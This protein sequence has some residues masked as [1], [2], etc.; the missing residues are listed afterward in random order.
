VKNQKG[1][2]CFPL[3]LDWLW[4]SNTNGRIGGIISSLARGSKKKIGIAEGAQMLNAA[5]GD[6]LPRR[7]VVPANFCNTP[8]P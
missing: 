4:Y 2:N 5:C 3:G 1:I 7:V 8:W 6:S